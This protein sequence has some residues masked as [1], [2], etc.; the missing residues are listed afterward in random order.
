MQM[1]RAIAGNLGKVYMMMRRVADA[2]AC[3][4][5]AYEMRV[6]SE[7]YRGTCSQV[8]SPRQFWA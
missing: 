4:K 2:V 6:G 3:F 5:E 8:L 7:D 1:T